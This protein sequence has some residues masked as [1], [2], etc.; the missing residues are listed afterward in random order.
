MGRPER[1][2]HPP[3]RNFGAHRT[4][5]QD[6]SG[7]GAE[8][9]AAFVGEDGDDDRS[10]PRKDL[11]SAGVIALL[12]VAAMVFALW[13]P[14]PGNFFSAPGLLPFLTGLSLF[15]MAAALAA[16]AL[17]AGGRDIFPLFPGGGVRAYVRDGENRRTLLLIV[18]IVVYVAAADLVSFDLRYP[19]GFFVLRFSSYELVSIPALALI[20]RIF[21]RASALR[22]TLVS[23]V[24]VI[25]LASVF[26][27]GFEILLPGAD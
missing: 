27:Y 21:W 24:A 5:T 15:V 4:V 26:R 11:V 20:L 13:L 18:I 19:T 8:G 3:L 14:N 25:A 1:V 23:L 7:P 22:C 6:D 16:G 17:R 2:A 12:S 10:S 9:K